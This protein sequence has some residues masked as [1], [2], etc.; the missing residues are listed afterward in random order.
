MF[1][2]WHYVVIVNCCWM[3]KL[4]DNCL[5]QKESHSDLEQLEGEYMMIFGWTIHLKLDLLDY[6]LSEW[7]STT[8]HLTM[9]CDLLVSVADPHKA[10]LNL[11]IF[12][13]FVHP[14]QIRV[15]KNDDTE[16]ER[17]HSEPQIWLRVCCSSGIATP[18]PA[19]APKPW[20]LYSAGRRHC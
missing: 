17:T 13:L 11:L 19:P 4:H 8:V 7:Q 5:R 3:E 6:Y 1:Y 16:F 10:W 18:V 20:W 12:I 15:I 9:K 2:L 14:V